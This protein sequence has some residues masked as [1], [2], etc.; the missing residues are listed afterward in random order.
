MNIVKVFNTFEEGMKE[1]VELVPEISKYVGEELE[2][3]TVISHMLQT[4][5]DD[6]PTVYHPDYPGTLAISVIAREVGFKTAGYLSFGW[7]IFF[8]E[9]KSGVTY[10]FR[11]T[12]NNKNKFAKLPKFIDTLVE[13]GWQKK[14]QAKQ[15]RLDQQ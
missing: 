9:D 4:I 2:E 3:K 13:N 6:I 5:K 7:Q 12:V 8:T 14:E 10:H 15:N 1:M 11:V